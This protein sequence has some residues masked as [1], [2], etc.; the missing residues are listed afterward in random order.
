MSEGLV[1]RLDRERNEARELAQGLKRE[2]DELRTLAR[3]LR[4]AVQLGIQS[5]NEGDIWS[6]NPSKFAKFKEF[7][8]SLLPKVQEVLP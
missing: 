6:V 8:K 3:E 5:Q 1:A 4:D 7:A 2:R